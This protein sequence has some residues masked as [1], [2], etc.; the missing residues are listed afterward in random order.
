MSTYASKAVLL[1]LLK[2]TY[3]HI[4]VMFLNMV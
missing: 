3:H 4:L 1:C 2:I